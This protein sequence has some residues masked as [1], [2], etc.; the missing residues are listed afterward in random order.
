MGNNDG[1]LRALTTAILLRL[2]RPLEARTSQLLYLFVFVVVFLLASNYLWT[3]HSKR[4]LSRDEYV[5]KADMIE[6]KSV[7]SWIRTDITREAV[8]DGS[9]EGLS[10]AQPNLA[11]RVANAFA[12]H[13]WVSK[14]S[15][16][17]PKYGRVIVELK[18]RRPVAMVW[19]WDK[20]GNASLLPVDAQG[21]VLPTADFDCGDD[22]EEQKRVN[23]QYLQ[24]EVANDSVWPA[25]GFGSC[26]GDERVHGA[27]RLAA[28]LLDTWRRLGIQRIV[29]TTPQLHDGSVGPPLYQLV[30]RDGATIIWGSS[31]GRELEG[32]PLPRQKLTRLLDL[33]EQYG[34]LPTDLPIDLRT[35]DAPSVAAKSR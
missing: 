24:V 19:V 4:V 17:N 12:L 6:L 13:P 8:K 1:S 21:I 5:L 2:F 35:S 15:R 27:A 28:V 32:E 29:V 25:A 3:R 11:V 18:F 10:L 34:Q 30:G 9:L 31:P 7:P 26:W 33:V 20:N 22:P 23:S 14:V 16:I